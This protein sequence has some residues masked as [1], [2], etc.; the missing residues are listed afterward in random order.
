MTMTEIQL[1]INQADL[2]YPDPLGRGGQSYAFDVLS[3]A[4]THSGDLYVLNHKNGLYKVFESS[5]I[6][7]PNTH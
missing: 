4:W 2:L 6:E 7:C 3:V 5:A 1:P